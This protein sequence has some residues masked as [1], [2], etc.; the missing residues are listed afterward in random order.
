MFESLLSDESYDGFNET[1]LEITANLMARLL[2]YSFK[3]EVLEDEDLVKILYKLEILVNHDSPTNSL[4]SL[5]I[6]A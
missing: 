2:E 6:R 1:H 3:R 4:K 5:H